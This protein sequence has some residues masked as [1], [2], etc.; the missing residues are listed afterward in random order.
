MS[1]IPLEIDLPGGPAQLVPGSYEAGR[2]RYERDG[3]E[4]DIDVTIPDD[5]VA[6]GWCWHGS[7][8]YQSAPAPGR[9]SVGIHT[10][11]NP[12]P[13]IFD[14]ARHFDANRARAMAEWQAKPVQLSLFQEAA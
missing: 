13:G 9:I 10:G 2:P 11:T 8:L 6:T 12:P 7:S 14:I 1:A 5:L 4:I 3:V